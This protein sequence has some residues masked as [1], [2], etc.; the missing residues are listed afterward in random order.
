MGIK[1]DLT[2]RVFEFLTVIKEADKKGK[3]YHWLCKC[4]CGNE[5]IVSTSNL[6]RGHTKSCGC[7]AKSTSVNKKHGRRHDY[8]YDTYYNMRS[9][10]YNPKNVAYENYGGR[11]IKM[12][13][14]WFN[15]FEAFL[16]DMGERPSEKHSLDR[17]PDKNGNYEPSNCRWATLEEQARNKRNNILVEYKGE[18]V[19]LKEYARLTN[20]DYKYLHCYY[21]RHGLTKA[22]AHF[23]P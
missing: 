17:F 10:C 2:G 6:T 23:N 22:I 7:F 3:I 13:D 18:K 19:T 1:F 20:V 9:R 12:C 21:K 8:I 15:S 5:S 16:K 4:K 11:G 14:S